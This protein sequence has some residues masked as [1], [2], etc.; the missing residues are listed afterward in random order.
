MVLVQTLGLVAAQVFGNT[1]D[2]LFQLSIMLV[3]LIVGVVALSHFQPFE[4]AGPQI[5]QVRCTSFS[6]FVSFFFL[7]FCGTEVHPVVSVRCVILHS[8]KQCR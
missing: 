3:I 5:V 1:L 7:F 8:K 4:Q 2:A 6:C